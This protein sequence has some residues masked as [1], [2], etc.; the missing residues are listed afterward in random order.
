MKSDFQELASRGYIEPTA[1]AEF[2]QL[3]FQRKVNLLH[4][5][6][7]SERSLGARLLANEDSPEAIDLLVDALKKEKK[8]YSKIEICDALVKQGKP[9]VKPLI[10]V[11]GK[12][13]NNQHTEV[14]QIPFNKKS[15]PLPRDIVART[16]S[17]MGKIALPDLLDGLDSTDISQL[18]E[19]VDAIGYIG[20][21]N[22]DVEIYEKLI[23]C[24]TENQNDDLIRWKVI[25]AMS[26]LPESKN[27]LAER[28]ETEKNYGIKLEIERSL[29][30]I[31]SRR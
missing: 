15:Y 21:Y 25:R 16:V 13:G 12:I 23:Q 24:Y 28:S 2:Q 10:S 5:N 1:E 27:F 20:F 29:K 19:I 9:A 14:P 7:P 30:L 17:R 31:S 6:I 26:G 8:L 11:L 22:Y 3:D 4:S 18:S